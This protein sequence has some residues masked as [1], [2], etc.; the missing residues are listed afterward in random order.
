MPSHIRVLVLPK[1]QYHCCVQNDSLWLARLDADRESLVETKAFSQRS[2]ETCEMGF[3]LP[4]RAISFFPLPVMN[5]M[6]HLVL[7]WHM[8]PVIS[9]PM[10][11]FRLL[12]SL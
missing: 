1:V 6:G 3:C 10:L 12:W 2:S 11:T 4:G 9:K 5:G 8:P 7:Y